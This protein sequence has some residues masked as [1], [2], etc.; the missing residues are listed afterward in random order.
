MDAFDRSDPTQEAEIVFLL[1]LQPVL[2]HVDTVMDRRDC[3]CGM[4]GSLMLTDRHVVDLRITLVHARQ[5]CLMRMMQGADEGCGYVSG[6]GDRWR[7][8]DMD[9]IARLRG[10]FNRPRYM[11]ELLQHA[12]GLGGQRPLGPWIVGSLLCVDRGFAVAIHHR[13]DPPSFQAFCK[14]GNEEFGA[15]VAGRSDRDEGRHDQ[16][17]THMQIPHGSLSARKCIRLP[18]HRAF[19]GARMFRPD[20]TTMREFVSHRANSSLRCLEDANRIPGV[21][22]KLVSWKELPG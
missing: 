9:Q 21:R 16:S 6:I 3:E 10:F 15:A 19:C 13:F 11:I 18:R 20:R 7:T 4:N 22:L 1:C 2:G 12:G 5:G 8:I 14:M 17:Y